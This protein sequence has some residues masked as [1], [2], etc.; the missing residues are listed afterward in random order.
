MRS[1]VPVFKGGSKPHA[2]CIAWVPGRFQAA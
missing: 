2:V 1:I